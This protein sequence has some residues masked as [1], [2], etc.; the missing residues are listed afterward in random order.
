MSDRIEMERHRFVWPPLG[1]LP[2]TSQG[3]RQM[4]ACWAASTASCTRSASKGPAPRAPPSPKHWLPGVSTGTIADMLAV[5]GVNPQRIY[6]SR[7]RQTVRCMSGA[8]VERQDQPPSPQLRRQPTGKRGAVS[9]R[10]APT[11]HHPPTR[12]YI[13]RRT[14]EGKSPWP[15]EAAIQLARPG[16]NRG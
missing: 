11:R 13:Q 6:R 15:L 5:P 3:Y 4:A 16:E 1:T 10:A 14:A 12:E 8:G 7:V 2:V 9:R